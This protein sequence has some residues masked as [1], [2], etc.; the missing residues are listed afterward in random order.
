MNDLLLSGTNGKGI[1]S[2]NRGR[3]K[4]GGRDLLALLGAELRVL[5]WLLGLL[6][7]AVVVCAWLIRSN[8]TFPSWWEFGLVVAV[9]AVAERQSVAVTNRVH[10]SVSFLPLVFTAVAFG[11]LAAFAA[12]LAANVCDFGRP[13]LRWAVYV[14]ARAL[15]GAAAGLAASVVL[16]GR[17]HSFGS[18]AL[19]ALAAGVANFVSDTMFNVG[20]LLVR[21]GGSV[22]S[23][24]KVLTPIA[25]LAL[26]LYIPI[27]ALI[28]YGYV[29]Y[30]FWV[31]AT[32]LIPALA[33]QRLIH[34]YQEQRQA[35]YALA[36]ANE[37]LE[38]ANLSFATALVAN[39]DARDEYT[40]GHSTALAT[41]AHE[42]A[43]Q[44]GL[45]KREQD[46][47][48]LA[49]LVHD[50]GKIGLPPGLLEKAAPLTGVERRIMESHSVV[51]E[52]I[53]SNVDDYVEIA[54]VVR[55][56]HERV[57]GAGY[58]DG[59]RGAEIPLISRILAVADAYDAMTSDR[60]YRGALSPAEARTKLLQAV[61]TQFDP[62]VVAAFEAVLVPGSMRPKAHLGVSCDLPRTAKDSTSDRSKLKLHVANS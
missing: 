51:G 38:N 5:A 25:L 47:A 54:K 42:I 2:L 9:A 3:F 56:H 33:L 18:V 35:T 23:L 7:A 32:F 43:K 19:A 14:P 13:L 28:T 31:A 44:M 48:H 15:T 17:A 1:L 41:N 12:A 20:T 53:L 45:E 58:P 46:R 39:L 22:A 30:S 40:A 50:I 61:E 36:E 10:L 34:L 21:R 52:T 24:I 4:R 29:R 55:H 11:P 16:G 37:H 60:P 26:P 57:D 49:G 6:V 59:L 27:V 8:V 62:A